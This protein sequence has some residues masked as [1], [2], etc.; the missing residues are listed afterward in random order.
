MSHRRAAARP[1]L[2]LS[3]SSFGG[4]G[5]AEEA[6]SPQVARLQSRRYVHETGRAAAARSLEKSSHPPALPC[7]HDSPP[8][9]LRRCESPCDSSPLAPA[10]RALRAAAAPFATAA[11]HHRAS[12]LPLAP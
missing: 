6:P 3:L 2:S 9:R 4:E 5:R 7:S 11:P 10:A 12:A 1:E 8:I